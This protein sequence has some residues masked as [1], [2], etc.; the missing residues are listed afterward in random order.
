MMMGILLFFIWNNRNNKH[1]I[2]KAEGRIAL[3]E[4]IRFENHDC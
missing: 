3:V 4:V 2:G 1:D